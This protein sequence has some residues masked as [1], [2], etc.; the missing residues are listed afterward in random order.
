MNIKELKD[1]YYEYTQRIAPGINSIVLKLRSNDLEA[2]FADI[3]NFSEGIEALIKIEQALMSESYKINSRITEATEIF[4][5]VNEAIEQEDITLVA[6]IFE[7]E[8]LP[9]FVSCSEW[10]FEKK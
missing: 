3:F 1:L 8:I 7:Y 2:A 4:L 5:Q 9:L 10:T 6:D